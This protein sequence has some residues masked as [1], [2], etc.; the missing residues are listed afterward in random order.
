MT[1]HNQCK[2]LT[3]WFLKVLGIAIDEV[4]SNEYY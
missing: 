4:Y 2:E 3:T 1:H